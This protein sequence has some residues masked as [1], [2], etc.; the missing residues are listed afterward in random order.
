MCGAHFNDLCAG[1][2]FIY[3]G[4]LCMKDNSECETAINLATGGVE[5]PTKIEPVIPVT[6]KIT[7]EEIKSGKV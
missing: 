4:R 1:Q 5:S 3:E 6:I 2:C 7:W